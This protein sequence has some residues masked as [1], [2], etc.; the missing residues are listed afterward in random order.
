MAYG[1]KIAVNKAI[2]KDGTY[3]ISH[4][5]ITCKEGI[6]T[7]KHMDRTISVNLAKGTMEMDWSFNTWGSAGFYFLRLMNEMGYLPNISLR[8][9]YPVRFDYPTIEI[10]EDIHIPYFEKDL[11][12]WSRKIIDMLQ[13][14][15]KCEIKKPF[16]ITTDKMVEE[17][18]NIIKQYIK[19][20]DGVWK[21]KN[22]FE[23][24]IDEKC[25]GIHNLA[26]GKGNGQKH[27]QISS[28]V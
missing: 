26:K 6:L 13:N 10:R 12:A 27:K 11:Q 24:N 18:L 5:D 22:K 19:G 4:G 23:V 7:L 2:Q 8:E 16:I 15:I 14:G 28:L 20:I 21:E 25:L 17:R 3:K 1:L 9:W